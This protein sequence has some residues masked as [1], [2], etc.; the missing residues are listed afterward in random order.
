MADQTYTLEAGTLPDDV[1][2]LITDEQSR[3][4][5]FADYL[6]VTLPSSDTR[7]VASTTKPAD[8]DVVWLKLDTLLR[9]VRLYYYANGSWI[10]KHT[11]ESGHTMIWTGALPDFNTFDGGS[12]GAVTAY[13]GPMWEEVAA[14]Q[15]KMPIGV[16]VLPSTAAVT[17]GATGGEEKHSLTSAEMPP[18]T[19]NNTIYTAGMFIPD[20][21]TG[22]EV[23]Q[24]ENVRLGHATQNDPTSETGGS[25]SPAVVTA[26]NNL[27]PY[28]GVFFLRR[29]A[30]IYF[31]EL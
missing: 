22:T 18:H 13:A 29:T 26:H 7:I 30:K 20:W 4:D 23:I 17:I 11:L 1:C 14:L 3:L 9:P 15:A 21:T 5:T 16:G 19:H 2:S 8:T 31:V 6:S 27:P 24:A 12:A 28:V 10:S 25:G